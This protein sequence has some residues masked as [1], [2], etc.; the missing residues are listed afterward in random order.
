MTAKINVD[1][2]ICGF[3]TQVKAV[4]EDSQNVRF[5]I[6]SGCEKIK[7]LSQ[8]LADVGDID[9]YDQIDPSGSGKLLAV[10]N[11]MLK[12]CCSG[13]AVTVGIF[14]GMQVAAGLALPKDIVIK[15]SKSE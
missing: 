5:E 12:G 3:H 15:I 4:S 11:E 10:F 1:G 7:A 6:H 14:K 2:G 8:R 9:A 13:C